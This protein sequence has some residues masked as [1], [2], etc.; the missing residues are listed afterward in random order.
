MR[1]KGDYFTDVYS[2]GLVEKDDSLSLHPSNIPVTDPAAFFR[3]SNC[4]LALTAATRRA[5][6]AQPQMQSSCSMVIVRSRRVASSVSLLLVVCTVL[7]SW[8]S[9][10]IEQA[11][12]LPR[13]R[14]HASHS[15]SS[16]W[17]H[18]AAVVA[19]DRASSCRRCPVTAG[20]GVASARKRCCRCFCRNAATSCTWSGA[21]LA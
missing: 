12:L 11:C 15:A 16:H 3:R 5:S 10:I 9:R 6:F 17:T 14:Q 20:S 4:G 7:I 1:L 19:A 21:L 2:P 8:F 18:E 13:A